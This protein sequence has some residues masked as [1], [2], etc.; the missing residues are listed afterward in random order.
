MINFTL[1][2]QVGELAEK[3]KDYENVYNPN[4][5]NNREVLICK[6]MRLAIDLAV[7][8]GTK[9]SLEG[10]D[11]EELIGQGMVGLCAAYEKY[12][13]NKQGYEGKRAKFSSVAWFWVNAAIMAEV[14]KILDRRKKHTELVEDVPEPHQRDIGK[15]E[16]LYKDIGEVDVYLT[17]LRFG[18][19][20]GKSLTYREIS[21]I[22]GFRVSLIKK[23]VNTCLGKMR[24][25]AEKYG[26]KWSDVFTGLV[27]I[28][29][30]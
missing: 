2:K 10:E 1:Y 7:K 9:Y 16:L 22:T 21:K 25:N 6:N 30:V 5:P 11:V 18:I 27:V 17:R 20:T 14:K 29:L 3:Y 23:S 28:I 8:Y 4:D 24:E 19:E 12:N 15:V 26:I 13:P